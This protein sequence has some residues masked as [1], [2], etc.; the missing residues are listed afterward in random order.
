[1]NSQCIQFKFK[2]VQTDPLL[3]ADPFTVL[4]FLLSK[5]RSDPNIFSSQNRLSL[6]AG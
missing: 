1:M 3:I 5:L 4:M 6:L 2:D